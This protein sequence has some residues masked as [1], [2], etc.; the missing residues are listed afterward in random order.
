MGPHDDHLSEQERIRA[1]YRDWLG[2]EQIDAYA[3]H[4]PDVMEQHGARHRVAGAMLAAALGHHL[5]DT[6]VVDVGCGSG[7]FLRQLI[8]WGADPCR[9]AGTEYQPQRLDLARARTAPGVY[10]HLGDLDFAA[11]ASFELVVANTVFS[12]IL[13]PAARAALAAEMWRIVMP[14]GWCMVFDFRYNNPR[15]KQVRRVDW[16]ELRAFWPT[17]VIR[18][19]T[20][21]LAP[22]LARRLAGAPRL[23]GELLVTLAPVLRSH[24]IY[25]ARKPG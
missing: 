3:W 2:Q 21:L 19:Q 1:V 22:P 7:G 20:L 12:S 8:D 15:N 24:F 13:D 10:W 11:D 25:M 17:P 6:R 9:L 23:L 5:G 18:H 16:H 4:R 14:G